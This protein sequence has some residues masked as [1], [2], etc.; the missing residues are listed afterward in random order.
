MT[1]PEIFERIDALKPWFH[2]IDLGDGMRIQRDP[3]YGEDTTYPKSVWEAIKKLL[4]GNIKGLRVLDVGCNAGY[5]SVEMKRAGASYVLGI[6][7]FPQYLAQAKL[8][9]D[10]LQI[11]LDL[12]ELN[13]YQVTEDLGQFDITLF[14]GVLYHLKHPLLA[15]ENLAKVTEGILV[16][17]S[18]ILPDFPS[19]NSQ[20]SDYGG[21]IHELRFVG[22]EPAG[23]QPGVVG[24]Q[25]WF[26]PS[27]TCL[28]A[29]LQTIGFR[30]IV[31]ESVAHGR[32]I[33]VASRAVLGKMDEALPD[34][35]FKA[36][37]EVRLNDHL[38][39]PQGAIRFTLEVRNFSPYR[40][41]AHGRN[42]VRLAYHWLSQDGNML[43]FDGER[44]LL[45]HDL[46]PT[47]TVSLDCAVSVPGSAGFYT[48]EFD[49]VQEFV[50]WFKDRGSPTTRLLVSV[51]DEAP[52]FTDYEAVWRSADLSRDYWSIVGPASEE[53]FQRL[54][55]IKL[56]SLVELGLT[57]DASILDV[58]CGTGSLTEAVATFLSSRGKYFGTDL[59]KE[60][61][62]FCR[63]RFPQA[64][65]NFLQ[66][67][68]NKIPIQGTKF[69]FI[70]F[71]SVFTHTFL[72]ET[73]ALLRDARRLLNDPGVIIAD[74]F[75][76][77]PA[78]SS[79]TH[80]APVAVSEAAF[81]NLVGTLDLNPEPITESIW[82]FG[83][84]VFRRVGFKLSSKIR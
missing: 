1:K 13:V 68:I 15:L 57:P 62:D 3:V 38:T 34:G 59:A 47:E 82:K 25:N 64:N 6:E 40:W 49:M 14:L 72:P 61:V 17:E 22:N 28:R 78:V 46:D 4:P 74:V 75:F 35:A 8:V 45:S 52:R 11:D 42:P 37:I 12:R 43:V 55:R 53:E 30:H 56:Q 77:S 5:F 9:R 27:L 60:A 39:T 66:N 79:E 7:G 41:P 36:Q 69:N 50:A 29:F 73:E 20:I 54:G 19:T 81:I 18:A 32:A 44:T 51:A 67:T 84:R 48:L 71:Y 63:S 26:I 2:S 80:R 21:P 31:A 76:E 16:V 58:G 24:L 70:V 83:S 65:F 23:N 10:I 33:V